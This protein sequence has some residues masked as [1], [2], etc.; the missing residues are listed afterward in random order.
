MDLIKFTLQQ[1]SYAIVEPSYAFILI[2]MALVF[3]LKNKKTVTMEKMIMGKNTYS[4]FELTV[5][6]IV[7][8][9]FGG[10]I[11][12]LLLTNMGVVFYESSNIYLLFFISVLLMMLNPKLVCFSYSGAILGLFSSFLYFLSLTLD[13]PS[14]YFLKV[15]ATPII[16]LVGVMHIVEGILVFFDGKRGAIPVFTGRDN[17]IAGGFAYR[18]QW[19]LPMIILMM[20]QSQGAATAGSTVNV[21]NWWPL[22]NHSTNV[23]IFAAAVIGAIPLFAGMN[24][25]TVTFTMEKNKKPL[26]SGIL[27]AVYGIL[28]SALSLLGGINP[29]LDIVLLIIMPLAHEYMLYFDRMSEK[30]GN[31]KYVSSIDGMCVL[32]LAPYSMAKEMGF[33]RGDLILEINGRKADSDEAVFRVLEAMPERIEVIVKRCDGTVKKLLGQ[34]AGKREPMGIVVVPRKFSGNVTVTSAGNGSFKDVLRKVKEKKDNQEH[35]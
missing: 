15:D 35:K 26:F 20:M 29:L 16:L 32:D 24:Y 19:I 25:S 7:M 12:S 30:K 18:R 11:A 1:V 6:Q 27:I 33:Q 4:G 5:S 34:V 10:V 13:K 28:M 31:I 14:I 21:P 8:G 23:E 3:Y 2:M 22:I 9:I 17:K